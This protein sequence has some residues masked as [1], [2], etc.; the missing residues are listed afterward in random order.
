LGNN[1]IDLVPK[2]VDLDDI[3]KW[4]CNTYTLSY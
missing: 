2:E 4:L 1:R 3:V